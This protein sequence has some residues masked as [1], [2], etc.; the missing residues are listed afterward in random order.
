M[1]GPKT[2]L[3][4]SIVIMALILAGFVLYFGIEFFLERRK[5]KEQKRVGVTNLTDFE[6]KPI[7]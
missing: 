3:Y 6:L 1:T 5:K 2:P 4:G 7:E